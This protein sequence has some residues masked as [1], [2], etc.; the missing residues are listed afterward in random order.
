V[1]HPSHIY[2]GPSCP[3][4]RQA[5]P[6]DL[7]AGQVRCPGCHRDF[8]AVAFTPAGPED[9]VRRM[10]EAGPDGAT[11]CADHPGNAAV[12]ECGRCGVFMCGLCRIDADGQAL[13][14]GCYER[15]SA[16][17]ALASTRVSYRD[18]RGMAA[19]L[20]ALG[21]AIAFIGPLAGP[22][23]V[24]CAWKANRQKREWGDEDGYAGLWVTGAAGVFAFGL[25]V[26][27]YALLMAD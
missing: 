21:I 14:P 11:P 8:E 5:L 9:S 4:C 23:A 1:G 16:E 6:E 19:K 27:V 17:G 20:A 25:G 18:F 26:A 13:C 12:S 7:R 2:A 10:A 15:L 22:G 3:H 24:Y